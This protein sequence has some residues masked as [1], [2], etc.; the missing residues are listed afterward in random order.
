[1]HILRLNYDKFITLELSPKCLLDLRLYFKDKY[2]QNNIY[3]FMVNYES[4]ILEFNKS[5]NYKVEVERVKNDNIEN[6]VLI[7]LTK[8]N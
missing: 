5:P 4:A 2:N 8:K 6:I 7:E 1:M 3:A